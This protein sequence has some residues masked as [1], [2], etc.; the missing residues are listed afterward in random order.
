MSG[1]DE[2]LTAAATSARVPADWPARVAP[3]GS[4]RMRRDAVDFL[5]GHCPPGYRAHR[6]L[7]RRPLLLARF[8]A[9]HLDGRLRAA[10]R[11]LSQAQGPGP[12]A[13]TGL[14]DD[15]E[16]V[17]RCEEARLVRASRSVA[18]VESALRSAGPEPV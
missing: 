16:T 6:L 9:D 17:L 11:A 4:P 15:A 18:L 10:R 5:L 2:R 1:V 14:L 8:A 12:T 7:R 3:P 13:G